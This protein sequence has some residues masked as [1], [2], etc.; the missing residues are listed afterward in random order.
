MDSI[1]QLLQYLLHIDIY[2][3]ALVAS[4]GALTYVVLF[5]II[6]CETGLIVTP[7]LPGDSLL[8]AAGS[9]AASASQSLNIQV[10]FAVLTIASVLGNKVNYLV[11]RAIGPRVFAALSMKNTVA[12]PLFWHASSPLFARLLR[13]W[14]G[15]AI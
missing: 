9:I 12:K 15:S 6:F 2:L 10:L 1:H 14:R 3:F 13:L 7:F 11:G 5:A 8:F 4:Y